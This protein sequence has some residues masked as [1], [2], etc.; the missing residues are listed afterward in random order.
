[1]PGASFSCWGT[2]S[3]KPNWIVPT[4]CNISMSKPALYYGYAPSRTLYDGMEPF[5]RVTHPTVR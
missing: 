4:S 3:V 1:M 5:R 2:R